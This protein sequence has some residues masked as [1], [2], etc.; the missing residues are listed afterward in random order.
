MI[1]VEEFREGTLYIDRVGLV[2]ADVLVLICDSC[3]GRLN[4]ALQEHPDELTERI[5]SFLY[6][7][8]PTASMWC[9]WEEERPDRSLEEAADDFNEAEDRERFFRTGGSHVDE[10]FD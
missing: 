7:H 3:G 1:R 2:E 10:W 9:R 8:E 4:V 6:D 5:R